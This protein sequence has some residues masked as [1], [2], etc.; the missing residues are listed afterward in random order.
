MSHHRNQGDE[1][2]C[3]ER[4]DRD[5]A[6][7]STTA[8]LGA[9]RPGAEP[10]RGEQPDLLGASGRRGQAD[11]EQSRDDGKEGRRVGDEGDGVAEGGDRH[12]RERRADNAPKIELRRVKRNCGEELRWRHQVR[13][14]GLLKRSDHGADRS[15]DRDKQGQ[16]S[17]AVPPR[18]DQEGD[19]KGDGAGEQIP[20]D[21]SR[22]PGDAVSERAP[23][24]REQSD[25]QEGS[26]GDH[27]RPGGLSGVR[28]DQCPDGNCL[29]PGTDDRDHATRPQQEVVP[30]VERAER[31]EAA[32]GCDGRSDG[33][34][35]DAFPIRP[36]L[37]P[38]PRI[39]RLRPRNH[40]VMLDSPR[41]LP[42]RPAG[43]RGT[44]RRKSTLTCAASPLLLRRPIYLPSY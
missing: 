33:L 10:K 36:V 1:G 9:R 30:V 4:H 19:G 15:L 16:E 39:W 8:R 3:R 6:Y 31:G 24:R 17:G 40:A 13:E 21:E 32:C 28:D 42:R 41:P 14:D 22:S 34:A 5:R 35:G 25:R 37:V 20:G 26:S 23:D 44:G 29:H 18:R 38:G 43:P 11:E 12:P 2:R 27:H 7:R